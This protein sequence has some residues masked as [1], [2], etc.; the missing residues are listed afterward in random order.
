MMTKGRLTR[1]CGF[2][3]DR[4]LILFICLLQ[5]APHARV[6]GSSSPRQSRATMGPGP[7]PV[8]HSPHRGR[9]DTSPYGTPIQGGQMNQGGNQGSQTGM[10]MAG[11]PNSS[12]AQQYL[13]PPTMAEWR[14]VR[15]D[16]AL[17]KSPTDNSF[18]PL[19]IP[20]SSNSED[21]SNNSTD[22]RDMFQAMSGIVTGT[23]TIRTPQDSP[24][25]QINNGMAHLGVTQQ[26]I[27]TS[28]SLPDLTNTGG[29]QFPMQM[30][31]NST[32]GF[33]SGVGFIKI[34]DAKERDC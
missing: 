15:S 2:C 11:S 20:D 19:V 18:I 16:P 34:I 13:H 23:G 14:R 33:G 3:L 27:S 24:N 31:P 30:D 6:M 32:G 5:N 25:S 29:L 17:H 10:P 4:L 9:T 28:G 1:K 7:G 22:P 8:R 21:S 26:N 12:Y